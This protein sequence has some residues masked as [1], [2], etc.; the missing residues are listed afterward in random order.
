MNDLVAQVLPELQQPHALATCWP[1]LSAPAAHSHPKWLPLCVL[2]MHA[3][4]KQHGAALWLSLPAAD[5]GTVA[6]STATVGTPA[7]SLPEA[8][9]GATSPQLTAAAAAASEL[10]QAVQ[11]HV[12]M[13]AR[14]P[15]FLSWP[16][17]PKWTV[18]AGAAA[19]EA[20]GFVLGDQGT[21][22]GLLQPQLAAGTTAAASKAAMATWQQQNA[23]LLNQVCC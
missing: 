10:L 9:C 3:A 6:G 1:L 5:K 18:Q 13:A 23:D 17:S 21:A 22:A 20:E 12:R 7:D 2:L 4:A 16:S 19:L 15:Q 14:R 11:Q 8:A